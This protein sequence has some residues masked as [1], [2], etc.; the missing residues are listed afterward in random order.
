MTVPDETVDIIK[1]WRFPV[2]IAA[3]GINHERASAF[4]RRA[5]RNR[6]LRPFTDADLPTP[7]EELEKLSRFP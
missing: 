5:L 3:R 6:R 1:R 2:C 7:I 4:V